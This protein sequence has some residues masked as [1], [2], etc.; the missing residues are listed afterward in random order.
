MIGKV[1]GKSPFK[2]KPK[3]GEDK[4][5]N[6]VPNSTSRVTKQW[7]PNHVEQILNTTQSIL[8]FDD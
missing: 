5:H 1:W 2:I 8:V 6:E 4:G 7:R 3:L